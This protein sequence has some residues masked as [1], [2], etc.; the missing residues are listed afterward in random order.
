MTF[1][2]WLRENGYK[3]PAD[4]ANVPWQ[5]S[6]DSDLPVNWSM[7]NPEHFDY[8]I[9]WLQAHREGLPTWL[10]VFP[11]ETLVQGANPETAVFVDGGGAGH[12]CMVLKQR[13]PS[14]VGRVILEDLPPVIERAVPVPG[15]EKVPIDF[16]KHQPIEGMSYHC[17]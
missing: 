4:P 1:P 15:M 17:K 7:K 3:D 10:D 6:H 5:L 9:G 14:L 13:H 8:F 2:K 11:F 12:Q 16:W